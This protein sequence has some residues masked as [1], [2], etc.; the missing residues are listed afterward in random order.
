MARQACSQQTHGIAGAAVCLPS[1]P[2]TSIAGDMMASVC[3]KSPPTDSQSKGFQPQPS[4]CS[5]MPQ[6][7]SP[8]RTQQSAHKGSAQGLLDNTL[9]A[10]SPLIDLPAITPNVSKPRFTSYLDR[11]S[12]SDCADLQRLWDA[13]TPALPSKSPLPLMAT[14]PL[15]LLGK[16]R[17][18][19]I[20][21]QVG[22][23]STPM[24]VASVY[25][26]MHL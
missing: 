6:P 16:R 24:A 26:C 15:S 8:E 1:P 4:C 7:S 3:G 11:L 9:P 21:P 25:L 2:A 19:D 13:S 12:A 5:T 23:D 20:E 18:A 22:F 10:L 17:F 14:S